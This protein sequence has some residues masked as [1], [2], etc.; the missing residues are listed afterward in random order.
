MN[1]NSL[2]TRLTL[3][4]ALIIFLASAISAIGIAWHTREE[5]MDMLDASLRRQAKIVAHLLNHSARLEDAKQVIA[6]ALTEEPDARTVQIWDQKG[7]L[8]LNKTKLPNGLLTIPR[9]EKFPGYYSWKE[10]RQAVRIGAFEEGRWQLQIGADLCR[11]NDT[12]ADLVPVY[13]I[14]LP[15]LLVT[16]LTGGFWLAGRALRPISELAAEAETITAEKLNDRLSAARPDDEI[17]RLVRVLNAMLERLQISFEQTRRFSADASHELRTPLTILRCHLEEAIYTVDSEK[18]RAEA[19]MTAL[20]EVDR[21]TRI[22]DGLLL[23]SRSDAGQFRLDLQALDFSRFVEDLIEDAEILGSPKELQ[24]K[25]EVAPGLWISGN[26]A[27]LRQLV[28]N[29][30]DNATKYNLP[31]GS[32]NIRALSRDHLAVLEISNTGP[33]IAPQQIAR[34]FDRFYRADSSRNRAVDGLGLG[35]AISREI[36]N[37][38]GGTLRLLSSDP[39][40]TKFEVAL[41]LCSPPGSIANGQ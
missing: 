1:W 11:I 3:N 19:L 33:G 4:S 15:L 23:L 34:L 31:N 20:G 29:L 12:I 2:R 21:L 38:H 40:W 9:A 8:V 36:A 37:A 17:G 28:L 16:I 22:V 39:H 7:Q 5:Q 27:Y 30:F 13:S 14:V 26:G 6:L 24:V 32:L 41:P 35:L 10:G 25:A 18:S